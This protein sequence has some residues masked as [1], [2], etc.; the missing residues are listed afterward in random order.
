MATLLAVMEEWMRGHGMEEVRVPANVHATG[1]HERGFA[2]DEGE[3]LVKAL[4]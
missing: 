1:F 4:G 3:I 2:K